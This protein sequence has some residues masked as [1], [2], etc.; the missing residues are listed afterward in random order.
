ML[1]EKKKTEKGTEREGGGGERERQSERETER[2]TKRESE[3][4][5]R[6]SGRTR[7]EGNREREQSC[8]VRENR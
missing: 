4:G 8:K 3:W 2:E 1:K 5:E 6:E 7:W